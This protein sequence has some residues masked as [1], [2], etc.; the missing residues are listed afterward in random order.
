MR[1]LS[2]LGPVLAASAI[3]VLPG[4]REEPE[5][6]PDTAGQAASQARPAPSPRAPE[7][8]DLGGSLEA[9]RADFNAR[10]GQNR[11][12]TLLAPT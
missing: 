7:L 3:L 9:I 4:C 2:A 12:I 10:R 8:I 1:L 11:F 5:P 6:P